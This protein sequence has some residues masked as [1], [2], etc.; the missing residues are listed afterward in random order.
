MTGQRRFPG[1]V[2][3]IVLALIAL[4]GPVNARTNKAA[5]L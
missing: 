2:Y 4:F 1:P 3:G 5:G